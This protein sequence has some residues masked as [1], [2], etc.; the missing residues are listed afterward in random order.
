MWEVEREGRLSEHSGKPEFLRSTAVGTHRANP[1]RDTVL[2]GM[3]LFVSSEVARLSEA[4]LTVGES[5][6]IGLF[7]CVS[8]QVCPQIEIQGKGLPAELTSE[9]LFPLTSLY[10]VHQHVSAQLR[11]VKKSLAATLHGTGELPFSMSHCV[12]AQRPSVCEYLP[13]S[14]D[15]AGV[16]LF[17]FF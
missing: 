13:A 5:A 4:L 15:V 7:T 16:G 9:R 6:L 11:V 1:L 2:Q 10:S 17:P 3:S 14:C 12:L 8:S